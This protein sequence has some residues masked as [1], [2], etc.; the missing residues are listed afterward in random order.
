MKCLKLKHRAHFVSAFRKAKAFFVA[1]SSRQVILALEYIVHDNSAHKFFA[2]L[3][4]EKES[5]LLSFI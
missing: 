3:R 4:V 2:S 1:D 5:T